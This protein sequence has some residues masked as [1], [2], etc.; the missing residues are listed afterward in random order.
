MTDAFAHNTHG[1]IGSVARSSG[2]QEG[3]KSSEQTLFS[4]L[5]K[6]L[7]QNFILYKSGGGVNLAFP[8]APLDTVTPFSE[9][10]GAGEAFKYMSNTRESL[11]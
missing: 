5:N 4:N 3:Q 6:T 10:S 2:R 8:L 11:M 1:I 7:H 9:G